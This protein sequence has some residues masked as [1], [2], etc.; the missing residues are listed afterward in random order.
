MQPAK[1]SHTVS[2][3]RAAIITLSQRVAAGERQDIGGDALEKL[4]HT[5]SFD[6]V[7]RDVIPDDQTA[8]SQRIQEICD[9]DQADLLCTTGGTGLSATD[10]TPE[11]TSAI[12]EKRLQGVEWLMLQRGLEKTP[13]AVLSRGIAGTRNRTLII[14][15]PGNP[16]GAVENLEAVL[17]ILPH[18]LR[19]LRER[20]VADGEHQP[21]QH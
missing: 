21:P 8:L 10:V 4:L 2:P 15:L 3:W 9:R 18:A 5:H 19:V 13:Y 12:I 20:Q 1:S 7:S 17:P 11:V 14:N 16:N 6:V